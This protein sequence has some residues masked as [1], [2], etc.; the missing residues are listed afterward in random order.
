MSVLSKYLIIVICG[1]MWLLLFDELIK[2]RAQQSVGELYVPLCFPLMHAQFLS[3]GCKQVVT[4][5]IMIWLII[6][7]DTA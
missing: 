6:H 1:M 5:L 2:F 7:K 4:L 3:A